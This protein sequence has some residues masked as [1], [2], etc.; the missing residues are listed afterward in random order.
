[1]KRFWLI[2]MVALALAPL[3]TSADITQQPTCAP[4]Y[5]TCSYNSGC[6]SCHASSYITYECQDGTRYTVA[7]GCCQCT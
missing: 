5:Q 4:T 7:G 6:L 1:M 3:R 2:L